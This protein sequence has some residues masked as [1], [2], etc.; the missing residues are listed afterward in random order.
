MVNACGVIPCRVFKGLLLRGLG[1]AVT[2]PVL[3]R[4]GDERADVVATVDTGASH[5]LFE[6]SHGESLGLDVESGVRTTFSTA[7][8]R[9]E[10]FGH[11]VRID[12]MGLEFDSVVYF[13]ADAG[14]KRNVLG[15]RGWLDRL[16][17]GLVDHDQ[18]V[19]VAGYDEQMVEPP[20]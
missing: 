2:L 6:R 3:L 4:V 11:E 1:D 20:R 9:F 16:R 19:Y 18:V 7:V 13:F 12:V 17:L 14:I 10:A 15:R 5:C 8:G